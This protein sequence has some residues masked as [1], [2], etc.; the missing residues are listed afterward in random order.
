LLIKVGF[1]DMKLC[2][3][4][5]K[6]KFFHSMVDK[7]GIWFHLAGIF[8]LVW[9]LVRVLP[10]P[11]RIR[12]PCQ[13]MSLGVALGYIAFWGALWAGIFFGLRL[14]IKNVRFKTAAFVP[15]LLVASILIFSVSSNVY[16]DVFVKENEASVL[17]TPTVNDPIGVPKGANPGRVVW[18]WDPD[19]TEEDFT[20]Y[21]WY[22]E[23][24]N[25]YVLD[26]MMSEGLQG[27]AGVSDDYQ[28]WEILFKYFNEE[29]G[30]GNIG[31]QSG[32]KIAIKININNCWPTGGYI[33]EDHELD[34]NPYVMKSLLKQLIDVVGVE[35][36][37]IT[38]YDSS[39]PM[40]NWYYNRLYYEYYPDSELV[41]EFSDVNY[42][43]STGRIGSREKAVA[44][45]VRIYFAEGTCEYRTLPTVVAEADYLINMPIMKRHPI[46][47]GVT[48]AGKNLFGSWIEQVAPIHPYHQ[49]G[50]TMGNPTVQTDLFAHEH[51]GGKTLLYLAEGL[52]S[53]KVDQAIIE[54]FDM[55]PFNGDWTNS[56]FFSQD[57]VAIDSVMYDFLYTED[58]NPTEGSQNYLHQSAQPVP[59]KYD[60]E[61][62][63]EYLDYS[64]G[65]HEHWDT[66][67]NIFSSERYVGIDFVPI[68]LTDNSPPDKPT[69]TGPS[70]GSPGTNYEYT[71]STTD[72]DDDPVTYCI[73]WSSE[74]G[75]VCIGP[76][77]S[78]ESVEVSHTWENSGSY[79]VKVKARDDKNAESIWATLSVSMPKAKSSNL[80][81]L[82]MFELLL[83]RF[84]LLKFLIN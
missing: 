71:I 34:A 43:D 29:H 5:F 61:N 35:E 18:V 17:W 53:T 28:A 83:S 84:S 69:I 49:S 63:G 82:K 25:Q 80:A 21:W 48:L 62:D 37:D 77:E 54:K 56:M 46:M 39:R 24:H 70:S 52:I 2:M 81:L 67:V 20:G 22:A 26:N 42:V 74:D 31:Y 72:P 75:E 15:V 6:K 3:R 57:P 47:S 27:I 68:P 50:Q 23:N 73:Y 40:A 64:L 32:E 4:S 7:K 1:I 19:A 41:P 11:D 13:Q 9:F 8:C 76:Y 58:T 10:K 12:Y 45:D 38:V 79:T 55:Y 36:S 60:P 51:L 44:S 59:N 65:V 33:S 78:G 30:K 16:A 66:S 14:W